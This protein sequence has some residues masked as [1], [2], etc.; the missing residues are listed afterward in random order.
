MHVQRASAH[1][2]GVRRT[3]TRRCAHVH[4]GICGPMPLL[5]RAMVNGALEK[6]WALP[7]CGEG[8]WY[9][10]R[11]SENGAAVA[12]ISNFMGV[13]ARPAHLRQAERQHEQRQGPMAPKERFSRQIRESEI[14][15]REV[16]SQL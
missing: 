12:Q 1:D 7:C 3:A 13:P 14:Y 16:R 15:I 8:S 9:I 4:V 2:R 10:A 6:P 5:V 11:N